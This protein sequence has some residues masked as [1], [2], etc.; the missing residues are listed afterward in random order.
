VTGDD[1]RG[2]DA[3][4]QLSDD[5]ERI[6]RKAAARHAKQQAHVREK[7]IHPL[8]P[9][10]LWLTALLGGGLVAALLPL[11]VVFGPPWTCRRDVAAGVLIVC[12]LPELFFCI[13]AALGLE[14]LRERV[15]ELLQFHRR[16]ERVAGVITRAEVVEKQLS[17][18]GYSRYLVFEFDYEVRGRI[19]HGEERPYI[20]S[21]W[22]M[23]RMV[24]RH[25][26]GTTVRVRL[27]PDDPGD[28]LV[29]GPGRFAAAK[30]LGRALASIVA[31][32]LLGASLFLVVAVIAG[33]DSL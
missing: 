27:A 31:G 24:R 9:R 26:P 23:K 20:H 14:E 1:T 19:R 11:L 12:A 15:W 30:L 32:S 8:G 22:I 6:R 33:T 5:L 17:R 10:W 21:K 4:P 16:T 18:G 28:A 13:L 2:G 25:P 29:F 3:R 7:E